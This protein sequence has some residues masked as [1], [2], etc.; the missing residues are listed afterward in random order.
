MTKRLF[1]YDLPLAVFLLSAVIG[2]FPGYDR[3]LS[4]M[5]LA[6]L[7]ACGA[8]YALLSRLANTRA[9]WDAAALGLV[10]VTV[11]VAVY[12]VSF[13]GFTGPGEKISAFARALSRFAGFIPE[14]AAWKPHGNTIGTFLEGGLFLLLGLAFVD[15]RPARLAFL[16]T[17][18]V[19]VLLALIFSASLGAWLAIIAAGLLWAARHWKPARWITLIVGIA[20]VGL[21]LFVVDKGDTSY[22]RDIPLAG[23]YLA[24]WF[25]RP[26]RF[27]VYRNS[28]A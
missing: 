13:F 5:T 4:M 21:I 3:S 17:G 25:D 7:L 20:L 16:L 23:G 12:Y 9:R 27:G 14:L 24:S 6:V 26:D 10:S 8:L 28:L 18:L 2:V 15:R 19:F 1:A 11:L 22:L